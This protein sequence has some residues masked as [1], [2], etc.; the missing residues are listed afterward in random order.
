LLTKLK[1]KKISSSIFAIIILVLIL[2]CSFVLFFEINDYRDITTEKYDFYYYFSSSRTDF[3]GSITL[4]TKGV[5]IS[6]D[7]NNVAINSTPIYYEKKE[8]G[9]ILPENMEIVYPYKNNPMYKIGKL[10]RLYYLNNYI[11]IKSEVG[12]G[13]IYDCFLYDGNDLYVFID[14]TTIIVDDV[15]YE[16]SPMSFVEVTKGYVKIYNNNK[17]EH[18]LIEKYTKAEAFT[19]EYAINLLT[20]SF[21]YNTKYYMLIK[22]IDKLD[23]PQF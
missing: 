17:D 22:N 5:I 23:N 2:V 20:D 9:M 1:N 10:S 12:K 14:D 7:A 18:T 6:L 11:Y 19:E 21:T 3:N 13:R 15:K 8:N 16:L 4:D